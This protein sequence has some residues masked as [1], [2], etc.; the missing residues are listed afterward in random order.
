VVNI[1]EPAVRSIRGWAEEILAVAGR[2][3][4]LVTVPEAVLPEELWITTSIAQHVVCTGHRAVDL[5]GW[6]PANSAAELARSVRWHLANPPVD[7]D[8]GFEVWAVGYSIRTAAP[9]P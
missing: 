6:R 2:E 9:M 5:L 1:G 4:E 3:A 8:P 7:A